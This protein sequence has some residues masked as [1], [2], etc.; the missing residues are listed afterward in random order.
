MVLN[1]HRLCYIIFL[2][3]QTLCLKIGCLVCLSD[4]LVRISH[5]SITDSS[6]RLKTEDVTET[7][8]KT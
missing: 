3:A 1:L 5:P 2:P 6:F 7:V 4:Y 8:Y